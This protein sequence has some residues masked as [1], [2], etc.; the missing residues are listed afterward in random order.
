MRSR[1]GLALCLW[2]LDEKDE[3]VKHYKDMLRLNPGDNQGNRYLLATSLLEVG[4]DEELEALF[5][6]YEDDTAAVW[7]YTRALWLFRRDSESEEA[8][9]ALEEA[10]EFN[11]HVPPLLLGEEQLPDVLPMFI[12]FGDESE[13]AEYFAGNLYIWLR[14]P[15]AL[16]W[17]RKAGR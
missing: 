9:K 6:R 8:G 5:D 15:N 7:L 14:T 10:I 2:E 12:G 13:A 11:P 16:E 4:D 1:Q 3:A 17:L